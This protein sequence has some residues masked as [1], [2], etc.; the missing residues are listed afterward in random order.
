MK[1]GRLIKF[2]RPGGDVHVYV[3]REANEFRASIFMLAPGQARQEPLETLSGPSE[4]ELE[5]RLRAWVDE[6]YPK[7]R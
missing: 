3:Y 4:T 5:A 6:R 1:T 2:Q 7:A